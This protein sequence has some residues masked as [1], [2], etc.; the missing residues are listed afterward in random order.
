[1]TRFWRGK[2]LRLGN[3]A[4]FTLIELMVVVAIIGILAAIAIALYANMQQHAR[5][6][7][8]QADL[9]AIMSAV[10]VYAAH[11][12]VNPTS[13]AQLDVAATNSTGLAAGPFL[14]VTP[15]PPAGWGAYSY[16]DN[17]NGTFTLTA[18]GDGT[19]ITMP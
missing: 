3:P 2:R 11:M 4:G 1:M 16:T 19:T 14:S 6:A 12:G 13:L 18:A 7:R 8:A 17:A 5:I 10:S 15:T 9:R